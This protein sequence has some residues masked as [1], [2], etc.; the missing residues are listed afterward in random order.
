MLDNNVQKQ[1][2]IE[3]IYKGDRSGEDGKILHI[4]CS[5]TPFPISIRMSKSAVHK[6]IPRVVLLCFEEYL[7]VVYM[8]LF[9]ITIKM[10]FCCF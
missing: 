2:D 3:G 5:Y 4:S 7:H 10:F 6:S 8:L 9:F 1:E